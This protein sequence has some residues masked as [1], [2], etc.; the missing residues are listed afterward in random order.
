M[1]ADLHGGPFWTSENEYSWAA[2]ARATLRLASNENEYIW[3]VGLQFEWPGLR[4]DRY[5]FADSCTDGEHR[6]LL[7]LLGI[8]IYF[9]WW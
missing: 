3:T 8:S 6:V 7:R 9:V 1:L 2:G 5:W 4:L